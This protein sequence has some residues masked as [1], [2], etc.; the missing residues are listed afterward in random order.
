MG[1]EIDRCVE[2]RER[3]FERLFVL[4]FK[5]RGHFSHFI[6]SEQRE[7]EREREMHVYVAL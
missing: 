2:E 6:L 1:V 5:S 7:R 4:G 3:E